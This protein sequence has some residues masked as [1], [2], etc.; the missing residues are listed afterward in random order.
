MYI[1]WIIHIWILDTFNFTNLIILFV[2]T[3]F[4]EALVKKKLMS[5]TTSKLLSKTM[6]NKI[7]FI[8]LNT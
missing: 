3:V 7:S 5:G 1:Y 6:N 2:I 4:K 8:C